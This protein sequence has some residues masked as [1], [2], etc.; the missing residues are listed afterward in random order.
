LKA[1]DF[2]AAEMPERNPKEGKLDK[3]AKEHG[4]RLPNKE[5]KERT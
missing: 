4:I 2:L 5:L 3:L 1:E